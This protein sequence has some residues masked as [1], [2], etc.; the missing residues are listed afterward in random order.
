ML[1]SHKRP[2]FIAVGIALIAIDG[3]QSAIIRTIEHHYA[4]TATVVHGYRPGVHHIAMHRGTHISG[5]LT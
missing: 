4:G 2:K 5:G 1:R 3:A